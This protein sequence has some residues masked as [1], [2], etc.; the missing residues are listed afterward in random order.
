M[1]LFKKVASF[2]RTEFNDFDDIGT[3]KI[4][5]SKSTSPSNK[6]NATLFSKKSSFNIL[7]N[8]TSNNAL[9]EKRIEK[10]LS[11]V[12]SSNVNSVKLKETIGSDVEQNIF[13]KDQ[14]TIHSPISTDSIPAVDPLNDIEYD[15]IVQDENIEDVDEASVSEEVKEQIENQIDELHDEIDMEYINTVFSKTRHNHIEFVVEEIEKG[16]NTASRDE[17]GNTIMHVCAQNNLR[18]LASLIMKLSPDI[19][20][21][22]ANKK[23]L[24]PLYYA[25]K[26]GFTK[27][28]EWLLSYGATD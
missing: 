24:T 15:G 23:D 1:S 28:A 22:V 13:T 14:T 8:I 6:E 10:K 26:Y 12:K 25:K 2:G 7:R 4:G 9:L 19:D 21:N 3:I 17:F 20:I 5:E 16:F 27:M 11:Q 18:K